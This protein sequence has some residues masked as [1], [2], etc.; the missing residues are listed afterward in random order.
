MTEQEQAQASNIVDDAS[1][2][3]IYDDNISKLAD[4]DFTAESGSNAMTNEQKNMRDDAIR[5]QYGADAR[6]EGNKVTFRDA[7]GKQQTEELT[8]DEIKAMVANNITT[9]EAARAVEMAPETV[10]R[11]ISEM[12]FS[13]DSKEAKAIENAVMDQEGGNL[14]A[15]EAATLVGLDDE[16]LK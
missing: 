1:A 4:I 6:I 12:G 15:E 11:V 9:K 8:N 5:A 7:G 13:K 16:K 3:K 10:D 2:K 14:T